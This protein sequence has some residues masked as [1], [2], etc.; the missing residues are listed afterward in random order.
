VRR[1]VSTETDPYERGR[2][3]GR[4]HAGAVTNTIAVYEPLLGAANGL[5]RAALE[6]AG[7]I[8]LAALEHAWPD[9]ARELAGIA[10]GASQ[11]LALLGAV[12]ARTELMG[13]GSAAECSLVASVADVT[14]AQTWDWHPQLRRSLVL[15]SVVQPRDRWFTTLT[16][17]GML[18]KIGLS[19]AGLGYG[20]NFLRSS[21]DGGVRGVPVHVV[22]RVLLERCDSPFEAVGLQ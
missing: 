20:L 2:M 10:D 17:A 19:S 18:A 14:L 13:G 21:E 5:D 22:L 1:H 9:L 7:Q 11:P 16:E 12:N 4:A 3:F 8:V 6:S 15:W